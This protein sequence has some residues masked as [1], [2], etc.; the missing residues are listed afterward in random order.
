MDSGKVSRRDVMR[1]AWQTAAGLAAAGGTR[2]LA[3]SLDIRNHYSPRNRV[4]PQRPHTDYIILHTTEG[5][6]TGSLRKVWRRGETHYFVTK[7]G[8]I[9]RVVEKSKIATH[10][11]RSMWQGH[12][13][14]DNYAIGIEVVGYHDQDITSA[15]YQA[16][17]ELLRQLQGLYHIPDRNVLTHSMVAYG[18]P[19]RFYPFNHRGRKRCGMIFA[20]PDVRRRLGLTEIPHSDPDVQAGRLKV[21]DFELQHYLYDYQGEADS[22]RLARVSDTP[23]GES[24]GADQNVITAERTAWYIARDQYDSAE[25]VYTF[26]DGTRHSGDQITDW[27]RIPVGTQVAVSQEDEPNGF[28]GFVEARSGESARDIAG[29][30]FASETTIYFLPSG[31]VRTGH[32][33][34]RRRSTRSLLQGLPAGTRVLVGYVYGGHVKKNRLPS[35]IAGRK[36]NYPSTFYRLPDGSILS[37]EEIDDAQIPPNTLVLFQS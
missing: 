26:P 2:L 20:R 6:E 24:P 15:Q 29:E 11:G 19:N 28:E 31:M 34:Q 35:R 1:R 4:R 14:I 33:L 37:G 10:A 7:S 32:D 3:A 30:S 13:P 25:T 23:A 9:Y 5:G 36:W 12:G 21:A 22:A 27:G 18:R 17:R 16:V 8:R